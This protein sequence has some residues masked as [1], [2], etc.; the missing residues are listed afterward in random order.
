MMLKPPTTNRLRIKVKLYRLIDLDNAYTLAFQQL[1]LALYS[2]S[3]EVLY[4]D[5]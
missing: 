3:D 2:Y 4:S 1:Q 5:P